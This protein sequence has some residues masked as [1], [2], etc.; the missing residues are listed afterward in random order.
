MSINEEYNLELYNSVK[1]DLE[2]NSLYI[3]ANRLDT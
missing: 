3:I 1:Y 2:S